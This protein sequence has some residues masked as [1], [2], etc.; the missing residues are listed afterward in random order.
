M[1]TLELPVP[2][3]G[4]H[5]YTT[6]AGR[7]VLSKKAQAYRTHVGKLVLAERANKALDGRLQVTLLF[8]QSDN[9]RRDIDNVVKPTLDALQHAGVFIDDSQ[10]DKLSIHRE[11]SLHMGLRVTITEIPSHGSA[12]QLR[13]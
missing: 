3:S 2:P 4:N 13:R 5:S 6:I 7:R 1:I 10:V 12:Q 9:R 8:M 11:N